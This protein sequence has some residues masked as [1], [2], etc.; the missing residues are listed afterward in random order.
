MGNRMLQRAFDKIRSSGIHEI[1][2]DSRLPSYNGSRQEPYETIIQN[3][4]FKNV[5]DR[6]NIDKKF[7]GLEGL[8]MDPI[9]R[10]YLNIGFEPW[11]IMRDF[12]ED[13]HSGNMRVICYYNLQQ[14]SSVVHGAAGGD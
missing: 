6:Y 1:F 13:P 7:P 12:I 5:I 9:I 4:A 14:D 10:F 2:V 3:R 8:A 11:L